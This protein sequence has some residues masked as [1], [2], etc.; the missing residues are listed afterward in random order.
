MKDKGTNELR[1]KQ[2]YMG[3]YSI[4]LD[5]IGKDRLGSIWIYNKT[6]SKQDIKLYEKVMKGWLMN[7]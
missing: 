2:R 6:L 7:G 1:I 4:K 3:V 5:K